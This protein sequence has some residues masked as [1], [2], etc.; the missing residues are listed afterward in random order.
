M[1]NN[2]WKGI[3]F[4]GLLAILQGQLLFEYFARLWKI[5]AFQ[6][7]PILILAISM[8]FFMHWDRQVRLPRN[9]GTIALIVIGGV[10]A[11]I[12]SLWGSPWLG[13]FSALI[14]LGAFFYSQQ[15]KVPSK[16]GL[17]F[18]FPPCLLVLRLPLNLDNQLTSGLQSAT[19]VVSSYLLDL[20]GIVH[21]LAGNVF[22]LKDGALFVEEACSGVQ[23]IFSLLFCA[24]ML[25]AWLRRS[26]ALI[27][28]YIVSA[29]VWA[30]AMNI[31]R[32][33]AI[34]VAQDW[35]GVDL[36]HGWKHEVLGYACLVV[37]GL[38][39]W[40]SDRLFLVAFFPVPR[41]ETRDASTN[42]IVDW[43]NLI[44]ASGKEMAQRASASS[45]KN[46]G[47]VIGNRWVHG[48]VMA[49]A[50]ALALA[51]VPTNLIAYSSLGKVRTRTDTKRWIPPDGVLASISPDLQIL[52]Q[53]Q[54]EKSEE[55]ALGKFSTLWNC[56][57]GDIPL[58]IAVSQ[59]D[60]Y[61]DLCQ[62]Y[63]GSGWRLIEKD[64]VKPTGGDER[65]TFVSARFVNEETIHGY[66]IFSSLTRDGLPIRVKP[67]GLTALFSQRF[68]DPEDRSM[69]SFDSES[70]NVQFWVTSESS[71]SND[72]LE[73]LI[74]LHQVTRQT[75]QASVAR[76]SE[77]Q[78]LE[79]QTNVPQ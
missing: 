51:V 48:A 19:S 24:L 34:A 61:H 63:A 49:I 37:A 60:E 22:F 29:I 12:A 69:A 17:L 53:T 40:S 78:A 5:E 3:A 76:E 44:F 14:F 1:I 28:F 46:G 75:I 30:L 8:L 18:L 67:T 23:S 7:F 77:R 9:I 73:Q 6:F 35:Y 10:F 65:W 74:A 42:P 15:E 79:G 33:T 27:P 13:C 41:S 36:A 70:M 54:A 72:L 16:W 25:V 64:V 71:L 2:N 52:A 56:V 50:I 66:L 11:G 43:W 62:C 20:I 21:R 58:R 55:S 26:P 57:L 39:L 31:V 4:W 45:V 59:Y 32:V 47:A 38:L 68:G